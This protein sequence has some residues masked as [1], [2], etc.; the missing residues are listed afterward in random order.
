MSRRRRRTLSLQA[1][2]RQ[3]VLRVTAAGFLLIRTPTVWLVLEHEEETIV[4]QVKLELIRETGKSRFHCREVNSRPPKKLTVLLSNSLRNSN[5]PNCFRDLK[6]ISDLML[7]QN[8]RPNDPLVVRVVGPSIQHP[9][10]QCLIVLFRRKELFLQPH[11]RSLKFPL[12]LFPT[13]RQPQI[14]PRV[15]RGPSLKRSLRFQHSRRVKKWKVTI[16]NQH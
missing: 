7:C 16:K 15:P 12:N 3:E 2:A 14:R 13:T 9:K 6:R 4:I 8:I 5:C 11:P 1:R 10:C